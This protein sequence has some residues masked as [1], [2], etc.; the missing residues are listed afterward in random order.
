MKRKE[1]VLHG[2]ASGLHL[3]SYVFWDMVVICESDTTRISPGCIGAWME[4]TTNEDPY[5]DQC[6]MHAF[7]LGVLIR[8]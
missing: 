7:E 4:Y 1:C 5:V 2:M 6:S 3:L 8:T